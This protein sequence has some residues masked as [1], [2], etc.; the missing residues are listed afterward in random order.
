MPKE[1]F[2]PNR[3][4]KKPNPER[5]RFVR[6]AT[7]NI[8]VISLLLIIGAV[9]FFYL[10]R[11][12]VRQSFPADPPAVVLLNRPE[13]MSDFLADQIAATARP[14][15]AHSAFDQQ[16]LIDAVAMLNTNPWIKQVH[17]VRRGYSKAPGDVLEIDCEYRTPIALV[18]WGDFFSLVDVDGVKL[19]EQYSYTQLSKIMFGQDGKM[20]IRIIDG[21]QHPPPEP[22]HKWVGDDLT[23]AIALVKVLYGQPFA[24]DIRTIRATNY[25][26]R[27]DPKE[28]WLV[29]ITRDQTEIRWGRSNDD[30]AEVSIA[31]KL[32]YLR[33]IVEKYHR[34]DA[35]HAAIDLRLETVTFPSD[36]E[37]HA[38]QTAGGP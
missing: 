8:T 5:D 9:G 23:S 38:S 6:E 32:D 1:R 37:H 4:V 22:G 7:L 17:Q 34:A 33:R 18:Q 19:P 12:V 2:K 14:K 11:Y 13:W 16:M 28:A 25:G 26:G 29:C 24:E 27:V 31:Q 15:T 21:I 30:A 35:N 10:R 3:L 36:E 20:N